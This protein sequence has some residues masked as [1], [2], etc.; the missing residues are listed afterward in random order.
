MSS[1]I[2]T[3][4]DLEIKSDRRRRWLVGGLFLAFAVMAGT[5]S[6]I[7]FAYIEQSDK[8]EAL[9]TQNQEILDDHHAI[10][11]RSP[12][13][14]RSSL[15]SREASTQWF[16][17]RMG[18][19]MPRVRRPLGCRRRCGRSLATPRRGCRS[20]AVFHP[21]STPRRGSKPTSTAM[22]SAGPGSR[23][24]RAG[25]TRSACGRDRHS[26]APP[27]RE[28]WADTASAVSS[29]RTE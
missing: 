28:R 1:P 2:P 10:G 23:S 18:W 27:N 4:R 20:P 17:P 13:R 3:G 16:V 12:S 26:T 7:A 14:R 5:L 19:A 29:G 9:E 24:S 6:L 25:P 22:Q 8:V 11:R 15:G 21:L